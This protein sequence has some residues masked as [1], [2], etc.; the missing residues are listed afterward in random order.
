MKQLDPGRDAQAGTATLLIALVLMMS[1]T[2]GTLSVAR[3]LVVEQR[4]ARNANGN[5]RLL[6]QA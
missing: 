2:I 6:L 4:M 1:I 5:T 3:T